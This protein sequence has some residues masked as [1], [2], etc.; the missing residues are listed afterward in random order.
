MP[1]ETLEDLF[2]EMLY[3]TDK[4]ALETY[5]PETPI[6]HLQQSMI[7]NAAQFRIAKYEYDKQ[8]RNA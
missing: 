4:L 7:K 3:Q 2:Q 8:N 6:Y 1:Q 5:P